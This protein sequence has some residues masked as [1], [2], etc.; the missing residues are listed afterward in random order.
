MVALGDFLNSI[1]NQISFE[2]TVYNEFENLPKL[3]FQWEVENEIYAVAT[4]KII[5]SNPFVSVQISFI[6]YHLELFTLL[7][8][9]YLL[10]NKIK[11]STCH[12][13]F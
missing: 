1:S 10:I 3:K 6:P 13:K 12:T 2:G 8:L 7:N 4:D 9:L 11:Y 5:L